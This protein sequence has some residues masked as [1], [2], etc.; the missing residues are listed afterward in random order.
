MRG[1]IIVA[2]LILGLSGLAASAQ[3]RVAGAGGATANDINCAGVV[4]NESVPHNTY[5]ITG[6]QSNAQIVFIEGDYIYI[7]KGAD[8]GAKVGDVFSIIRPIEDSTKIEWT[9]WQ[10]SILRKMGTVWEDEG[11]AR[12]VV[13]QPKVSIAQVQH[14]CDF[15]QRGDTA[16]A[17]VARPVPLPKQDFQFDQFAPSSGKAKAMVITG[18]EFREQVGNNEIVYVNLGNLQG[19][20]EGDYFRV[21]RYEGTEHDAAFQTPRFSF[22]VA[23]KSPTYGF[24]SSP[25][26]WNWSNVPRENIGEG[27][28][29]R[30]GPNSSTVLITFC[31]REIYAGDYVELE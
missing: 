6:Q 29:L 8:Q 30:T 2:G 11:Q 9:K 15:I 18:R 7:N 27:V 12:I 20:K 24:G 4:T 19:V 23:L 17:Y 13:V 21:F 31:L 28:V 22:D 1:K 26:E 5:V 14:A 16:L 25:K 10:T 3:D